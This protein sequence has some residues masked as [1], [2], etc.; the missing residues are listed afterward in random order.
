M[1]YQS[2]LNLNH[3]VFFNIL[4]SIVIDWK[5]FDLF[6]YVPEY[7]ISSILQNKERKNIICPFKIERIKRFNQKNNIIFDYILCDLLVEIIKN[8]KFK[9]KLK[10]YIKG[11]EEN[12]EIYNVFLIYY[13]IFNKLLKVNKVIKEKISQFTNT[14][15]NNH[16]T[17]IQIRVGNDDLHE[18]KFSD[19]KDVEVMI[20]L[21]KRSKYYKIWYLTGDSQRLKTILVKEYKNI[22]IYSRNI[23][24]HYAKNTNDNTIVIEHEILSKSSSII[25]SKS[26]YGLTASLKSGLLLS[27]RNINYIVNNR[28]TYDIKYFLF[29]MSW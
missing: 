10:Y 11:I 13:M 8:K 21:A 20:K 15:K 18:K 4:I 9:G 29:N 14:F 26:T 16:F 3:F 24:K 19:E 23:T 28:S 25:I 6:Y 1:Y 22:I 17:G 5:D 12:N 7:N 2:F 27:N